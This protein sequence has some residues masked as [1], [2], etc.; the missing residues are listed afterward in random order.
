MCRIPNYFKDLKDIG[1]SKKWL[2]FPLIAFKGRYSPDIV[3]DPG[4]PLR[5]SSYFSQFYKSGIDGCFLSQ[6]GHR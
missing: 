1:F 6:I 4:P 5:M 2:N 3:H